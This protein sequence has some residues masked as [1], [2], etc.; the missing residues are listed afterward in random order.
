MF[1]RLDVRFLT[2]AVA[3]VIIEGL[4]G[5]INALQTIKLA[6][7]SASQTVMLLVASAS[8]LIVAAYFAV[9]EFMPSEMGNLDRFVEVHKA[10][11]AH[12]GPWH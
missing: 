5:V 1:M 10:M 4:C 9:E 6:A 8:V 2:A 12:T 3:L 7:L 11:Q